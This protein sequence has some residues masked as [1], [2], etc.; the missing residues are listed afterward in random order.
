M[1]E[2]LSNVDLMED[3]SIWLEL[4]SVIVKWGSK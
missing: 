1:L 2:D 3:A 4:M